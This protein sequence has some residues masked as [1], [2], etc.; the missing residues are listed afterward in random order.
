MTPACGAKVRDLP[1]D[2]AG[3]RSCGRPSVTWQNGLGFCERHDAHR[4]AKRGQ[5]T[6]EAERAAERATAITPP[7]ESLPSAAPPPEALA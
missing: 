2:T 4:R 3:W 7:D 5:R 6:V 1:A